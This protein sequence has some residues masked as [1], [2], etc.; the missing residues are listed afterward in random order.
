MGERRE[1]EILGKPDFGLF[2]IVAL[3]T[4]FG[5]LMVF[6]ASYGK[7]ADAKWANFDTLYML[8]RQI[9]YLC[10]GLVLMVAVSRIK[11]KTLRKIS[12]PLLVVT[13]FS[14]IALLVV[15]AEVNGAKRWFKAGPIS[16][17][18]SELAKIAIV[19][20]L[21]GLLASKKI[22]IRRIS[23]RWLS[24]LLVVGFV[25]GVIFIQ[26]DMGTALIIVGSSFF[27]LYGAGARKG[28][29]FLMGLTGIALGVGALIFEPYRMDRVRVWLNPWI[30]QYDKGYQVIHSLMAL[31]TGGIFGVGLC[32]GREKFYIPASS[33]DFIFSTIGEELSLIHI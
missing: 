7:T 28:H 10:S 19:L 26:P 2:A 11:L 25:S 3:L 9:A 24:P 31:G 17:Q 1:S 4:G 27:M 18:P 30:D 12:T 23:E 33:T 22:N 14:L 15:G 8:K 32:E 5:A 13:I 16:I 21:A 29:L 6:D 20:Y